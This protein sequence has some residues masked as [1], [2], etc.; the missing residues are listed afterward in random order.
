MAS[1]KRK[2]MQDDKRFLL[3]KIHRIEE[4]QHWL[5]SRIQ[6]ISASTV[7][8]A[9]KLLEET[10]R[11]RFQKLYKQVNLALET[12]LD[13]LRKLTGAFPSSEN[14]NDESDSSSST[15]CN[16]DS[17]S[18]INDDSV[19]V[20][21]SVSATTVSS[22]G[23]LARSH[24]SKSE[25]KSPKDSPHQPPKSRIQT[26][27]LTEPEQGQ[28]CGPT[29]SGSS[30]TE[31]CRNTDFKTQN[32]QDS[33]K[34]VK[35]DQKGMPPGFHAQENAP[36]RTDEKAEGCKPVPEG[37][38]TN[39]LKGS[40]DVDKKA[41]PQG[42]GDASSVNS[43]QTHH[44]PALCTAPAS[45]TQPVQATLNQPNPPPTRSHPLPY[46]HI[47]NE[48]Q[49]AVIR[50][51]ENT[52]ISQ[53]EV[54]VSEVKTPAVFWIQLADSPLD[55]F[56]QKLNLVYSNFQNIPIPAPEI[57]T[58]CCACFTE[59]NSWY[60]ARVVGIQDHASGQPLNLD[61]PAGIIVDV[62][63]VDYGNREKLNLTRVRVINPAFTK[64]PAQSF[65]CSMAKIKPPILSSGWAKEQVDFFKSLLLGK[66]VIASVKVAKGHS[67]P[68]LDISAPVMVGSGGDHHIIQV[69]V[70]KAMVERQMAQYLPGYGPPDEDPLNP[71]QSV[72]KQPKTSGC[73]ASQGSGTSR[74]PDKNESRCGSVETK[75]SRE[76]SD[77][78]SDTC[79]SKESLD[80]KQPMNKTAKPPNQKQGEY[81]QST[82]SSRLKTQT[83]NSSGYSEFE[84]DKNNPFPRSRHQSNPSWRQAKQSESQSGS[85]PQ[86]HHSQSTEPSRSHVNQDTTRQTSPG[87]DSKPQEC[88]SAKMSPPHSRGNPPNQVQPG[89]SR[90]HGSWAGRGN[91]MN[92][93]RQAAAPHNPRKVD[94]QV[95][96]ESWQTDSD[97][98]VGS[99]H[100][101]KTREAG[102]VGSRSTE[103][104]SNCSDDTW[105]VGK[106]A[107]QGNEKLQGCKG[108]S[109]REESSNYPEEIGLGRIS[110]N[111]SS[112]VS[113]CNSGPSDASSIQ[114]N[115]ARSG[116]QNKDKYCQSIQEQ[117]RKDAMEGNL[118]DMLG[119]HRE[120]TESENFKK[121]A[122]GYLSQKAKPDTAGG[123][124]KPL[125]AS[126][127]NLSSST[128]SFVT[129]VTELDTEVFQSDSSSLHC[130]N[131]N[132]GASSHGSSS[133]CVK[134]K[135][136]DHVKS[137]STLPLQVGR[138]ESLPTQNGCVRLAMSHIVSPQEFY[139][140]LIN[141]DADK[142]DVLA[143][144]LNKLYNGKE[145]NH[146]TEEPL[147]ELDK[148]CA[149]KYSED[150]T[151][152]R[153]KILDI[154]EGNTDC[155]KGSSESATGGL[156][157]KVTYIDFGNQEWLAA[158]TLKPLRPEFHELP[159]QVIKCCL[160]HIEP[161][162]KEESWENDAEKPK[163]KAQDD[164]IGVGGWLDETIQEFA[165]MTGYSKML[166]GRVSKEYKPD[167]DE[168][169]QMILLDPSSPWEIC[170][171]QELVNRG[172]AASSRFVP[173]LPNEDTSQPNEVTRRQLLMASERWSLQKHTAGGYDPVPEL[174]SEGHVKVKG[175]EVMR[176][177][178]WDPMLSDYKS[179]RNSYNIDTDDPGVATVGYKAESTR[180]VCRFYS[181]GRVC[182][183]GK[184]CPYDHVR[185]GER[186]HESMGVFFLNNKVALPLEGSVVA[187]EVTALY[188]AFHFW[189]QLPFSARPL[190]SLQQQ[191]TPLRGE[192]DDEE[193][194]EM[195][196]NA[197]NQ[198]Y[199][200][201]K[202]HLATSLPLRAPGEMV[203]CHC[204]R[205]QRYCRAKVIDVNP[206]QD[207]IQVFYVDYGNSEWV[208][209]S[210]VYDI[211]Q[212]FLHLPLQAV[213]CYL[214]GAKPLECNA[215]AGARLDEEARKC[216]EDMVSDKTLVAI[217]IYVANNGTLDVELYDTNGK[218]DVCISEALIE[219][220]LAVREGPT[221]NQVKSAE[222]RGSLKLSEGDTTS[223]SEAT[224]E[225]YTTTPG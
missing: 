107:K 211:E 59:D 143:K 115:T 129:A 7:T 17:A 74:K 40:Q 23:S 184:Q 149:A 69:D 148:Y 188:S 142:L 175:Q 56:A 144:D 125:S 218:S 76:V 153:A 19:S 43:R 138:R 181:S 225:P 160:A 167:S 89:R 174:S 161:P 204:P 53:V 33:S 178:Q 8:Q 139:I 14:D 61:N 52:S 170:I 168:P 95:H 106:S 73:N 78:K 193:T 55:T 25:R 201:L 212:Q 137:P 119:L 206:D 80:S 186:P 20:F 158:D 192:D 110:P 12:S 133:R 191:G 195:L 39:E 213:E 67:I 152:Y 165:R 87:Q 104:H 118:K 221:T 111:S 22:C 123:L 173:A 79:T 157:V 127:R 31:G 98:G 64:L 16:P 96:Q 185:Q 71:A 9:R 190:D 171:N 65:C 3:E 93:S 198:L 177:D 68:S 176:R 101:Q 202:P 90:K 48:K 130:G 30:I 120:E 70:A 75:E 219:N 147:L 72:G 194:L 21:S 222:G 189:A 91:R 54:V 63:Y 62:I 163:G 162:K 26:G 207:A 169:L 205:D 37:P 34:M 58:F 131:T 6:D 18:C 36:A 164:K 122:I 57:G 13:T 38:N 135:T 109:H 84:D 24:V 10:D 217:I 108:A 50:P 81:N 197:M 112:G 187:L 1:S 214:V 45:T 136:K 83:G 42:S 141:S 47:S 117:S 145:A 5:T 15:D 82:N 210:D 46:H 77:D 209:A 102:S 134:T 151:W 105:S 180:Q 35:L 199:S 220:G 154:K 51:M 32:V 103:K 92:N 128:S 155:S 11:R 29:S 196:E 49:S 86:Q 216:F 116:R 85:R 208:P 113:S 60:R 100:P 166:L 97:R 172:L 88:N 182:Y 126:S 41:L 66:K 183:R 159:G 28:R 27:C 44:R 156:M 146:L 94:Q 114:Q 121:T 215:E 124:N 2:L 200:A 4:R 203:C 179:A 223:D 140:H 132:S 99:T 224:S 150:G